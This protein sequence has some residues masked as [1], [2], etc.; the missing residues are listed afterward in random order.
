[1]SLATRLGFKNVFRQ[2][3]RTTLTLLGIAVSVAGV[4]VGTSLMNGIE[5]MVFREAVGE[6][7]EIVV[8][9]QAYFEKSRFNP[10]KYSLHD[11]STLRAALLEVP[12]V[13]AAVG[14]IDFG[15]LADADER[16]TTLACS[17]VDVEQFSHDSKIPQRL[18]AGRFLQP[19]EKALVIGKW[20]A[21]ELEVEPGDR[22]TVLGRTAYDAFTADDFEIVGVVD[23]GSKLANRRSFMP[24][25][26]AQEFLEM[27][28]AV[29]RILLYSD[30]YRNADHIAEEIRSTHVLGEGVLAEPWT[31]NFLLGSLH[32][33]LG[34]AG[35]LISF[36]ICFVSGLGILNMMMVTV[37][38]RRKEIGVLM[39]LGMSRLTILLS[40]LTE[41]V[42]YGVFGGIVGVILGT[43]VALYLDRVGISFQ[44]D[45]IQGMPM[46]IGNTLHADFGLQSVVWGLVIGILLSLLGALLPVLKTS[47]MGPLDAM[48]R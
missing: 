25:A 48:T 41:A 23:M 42:L 24:L 30:D 12:G 13:R 28:N 11:Y 43:P 14:R 15:F 7:G 3:L 35:V 10:L 36:I 38:E 16:S 34:T 9:R 5:A 47:S 8:A 37:L 19:G 18:I 40:F 39:A 6:A 29:S 1:M 27:S 4:L 45:K 46:A 20:V 17:A 26:P 32:R 44:A 31:E 2:P 22:V 21:E 33:L